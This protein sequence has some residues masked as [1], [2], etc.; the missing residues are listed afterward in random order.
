MT[1]TAKIESGDGGDIQVNSWV[2]SHTSGDHAFGFVAQ[3]IG[4]GGGIV[5]AGPAANIQSLSLLA[6]FQLSFPAPMPTPAWISG[7]LDITLGVNGA[8]STSSFI[9][10]SGR[11]S[12]GVV[13]QSIAGGG[14]IG[15]DTANG[16]LALGWKSGT[17]PDSANYTSGNITFTLN[18]GSS[19]GIR[20][21]GT[22]AH[23]VIAQS[24][25]APGG[26]G[27]T[28]A[29]SFAG[30]LGQ[31]QNG[32]GVSGS[33]TLALDGVVSAQGQDAWA[34]FAQ[35]YANDPSAVPAPI[36]ITVGESVSGGLTSGQASGGAIWI[37]SPALSTVTVDAAATLDGSQ[38]LAAVQ[39]TSGGVTNV[40]NSGTLR[41]NLV[42]NA[43]SPSAISLTN[44]GTFS[45]A[46][47]VQGHV[48]NHGGVLIGRSAGNDTLRVTGDFTQGT[49]G[50]L[51]VGADFVAHTIDHL[52]VDGQAR[53]DGKI[54]MLARTLMPDRELTFLQA[55]ALLPGAAP[56]NESALFSYR[57]RQVGNTLAL[58]VEGARF[59]ELSS[60][61][62]LEH[63][64]A[65]MGRHLQDVWDRGSSEEL[66]SVYA[67][68]DQLT[69][70]GG[71]GYAR[72]LGALSPGILAAPAALKQADLR[73]F[74]NALLNC[75]A[76]RDA[77]TQAGDNDCV[78]GRVSGSTTRMDGSGG[79]SGLKSEGVSYQIGAQRRI[80]PNW[81]LGAAGAY[82]HSTI[83]ADDGRAR[84]KGDT[85][86]LGVSLKHE[87]GPWTVSAA[88]TGSHGSFDNSRDTLASGT[89][90]T[91][92][93]RVTAVGQRVS[94][95]YTHATPTA[96]IKPSVDVDVVHTRTSSFRER[97]AGPLNL[98]VQGSSQWSATVSP[99][100]EVGG[101]FKLD[102][103]YT[104][105]PYASA[106][107]WSTQARLAGA[108]AN[109]PT[110]NSTLE[111]GKVFGQVSAGVQIAN[112]SGVEVRLQYDGVVS[113]KVRSHAASLK[114]TWRF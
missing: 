50:E 33:I 100:V 96:Y 6:P 23:G 38:G 84:L 19:G 61:Y 41:G 15:G 46:N 17:L 75:P 47:L 73:A 113:S 102:N 32:V 86:Y 69:T 101:R 34:V 108:P 1:N 44:S 59:N 51:R 2:S 72:A 56:Q 94:V 88:L 10:T 28:S 53:L 111:T 5:A 65:S 107:Q 76:D 66:G 63:N 90:A 58:S 12:H 14:G 11:G 16:P 64:L 83:R 22:G 93:S 78:W 21:T 68:L 3:S 39:Q 97:G 109:T 82:Q 7:N 29:G 91:S 54:Q 112:T 80:A 106:D 36:T 26:L 48:T 9:S 35:T 110:F 98:E 52:A 8:N 71:P 92:D 18:S 49:D 74:S 60:S 104:V 13:L 62:G 20:T 42:G 85:G 99:G 25:A 79:T 87:R 30:A 114:A 89:R 55:G 105:R 4:G 77:S 70:H 45:H 103:G 24:L 81:F 57:T 40:T 43:S 31:A 95:S 27:G 37:D 67:A